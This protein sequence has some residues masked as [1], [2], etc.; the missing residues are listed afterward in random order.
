[1]TP[2]EVRAAFPHPL[3]PY[4]RCFA[5]EEALRNSLCSWYQP[6][7]RQAVVEGL[8]LVAKEILQAADNL[9]GPISPFIRGSDRTGYTYAEEQRRD[10]RV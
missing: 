9:E 7:S 4:V 5:N 2:D 1:M 10:I 3:A 8:R 6:L